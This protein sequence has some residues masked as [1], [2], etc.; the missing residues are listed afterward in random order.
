MALLD[1]EERGCDCNNLMIEIGQ[2][3]GYISYHHANVKVE[4][5]Q[6]LTFQNLCAPHAKRSV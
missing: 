3:Q 2:D 5:N 1:E 4:S 6:F